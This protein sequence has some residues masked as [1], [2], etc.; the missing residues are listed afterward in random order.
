MEAINTSVAAMVVALHR[1][2]K[3]KAVGLI[4][5]VT[6]AVHLGLCLLGACETGHPECTRLLLAAHAA[7]NHADSDGATP[8]HIACARGHGDCAQLLLAAH[9]AVDQAPREGTTPL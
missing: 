6:G 9:A 4:D 8:L 5:R 3:A 7:V 1:N 2:N